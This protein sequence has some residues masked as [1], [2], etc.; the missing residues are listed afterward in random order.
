[1]GLMQHVAAYFGYAKSAPPAEQE[2]RLNEEALPRRNQRRFEAAAINRLTHGFMATAASIDQELRGELDRLRGR[3]RVLAQ[4]NEYVKSF[5]RKLGTNVVGHKGVTLQS[6]VMLQGRTPDSLARTAIEE[7]FA[8]WAKKGVC[9]ITG[10]MGFAHVQRLLVKNAGRDGEFLVRKIY[11][12]AAKNEFGFALQVIDIDRLDTN[13]NV[14]P[15]T[16]RNAVIMGVEVD[17]TRRPVA[18]HIFSRHPNDAV[19]GGGQ[20]ERILASE[21]IHGFISEDGEQTRGYTWLHAGM[22]RM[23]HLHGYDEA[24]VIAARV[25]AAKMGFYVPPEGEDPTLIGDGKDEEEVPFAEAE[26]GV[27]GVLPRGWDFKEWD[28]TYPHDQYPAF[29][30]SCL[31]GIA[32][33]LGVSYNTLANDLEG[34]NF[35]SMRAGVLEEREVWKELQDWFIEQFCEPVFDEWLRWALLNGRIV[36]ENGS[37]LPARKYAQ[38]SAHVWQGRRWAWVD[39]LKDVEAQ[40]VAIEKGLR[41]RRSVIAEGGEDIDDVFAELAQEK[42]DAEALGLEFSA[43]KDKPAQKQKQETSPAEDLAA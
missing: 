2:V 43:A 20:R 29:V 22:K 19:S 8:R 34:V 25:G 39:P 5:L 35:S 38:F 24:A 4:N 7:A 15:A 41:T 28:P 21:I 32:S 42:K 12:N 1:M 27:F 13:Y 23:H 37:A 30:K 6:R 17:D 11:G 40:V 10:R 16:G 31:R 33:G 9:E 36:L 14:A 26:A 3:A 18:Y